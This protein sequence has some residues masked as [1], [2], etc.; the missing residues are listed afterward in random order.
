[1]IEGLVLDEYRR[2]IGEQIE[3]EPSPDEAPDELGPAT[4]AEE[5]PAIE[6]QPEEA[7]VSEVS[8]VEERAEKPSPA[9]VPVEEP[10]EGSDEEDK[11]LEEVTEL[12]L[13]DSFW[14]T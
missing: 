10:T 11:S 7:P 14:S 4:P 2:A 5:A 8:A 13:R 3:A 9:P 6:S 12:H 1:M